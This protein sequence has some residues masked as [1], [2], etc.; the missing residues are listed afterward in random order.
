MSEGAGEEVIAYRGQGKAIHAPSKGML[1]TDTHQY[2]PPKRLPQEVDQPEG[3][4]ESQI[5]ENSST[6]GR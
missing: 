2:N 5:S 1:L 3:I 6:E 4:R